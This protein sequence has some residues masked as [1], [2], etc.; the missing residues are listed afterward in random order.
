MQSTA[1]K[2][3]SRI[4]LVTFILFLSSTILKAQ[5]RG[6]AGIPPAKVVV[7]GVTSGMVA[8]QSIFVGTVYYQEVADVA[9]EVNGLV[10]EVSFEEGERIEKGDV[11]VKLN[12]DLL[13]KT[14]Q[15]TRASYEKV[16][17]DL[18]KARIDFKR[19]ESLY[20]EGLASEQEYDE[21]GFRVKGQEK[22]AES[23]KAELERLEAE[24][25]R[26]VIKAPF[27]GVVLERQANIGEWLSPGS[28]VATIARSEVVDIVVN[29]PEEVLR[30]IRQGQTVRVDSG[31]EDIK[32]KVFTI[33]PKGDVATRTF[34]VKIR[35][36][37]NQS[38]LEGMEARVTLP[39]GKN[40][41]S[42]IVPRDAVI[43]APGNTVVFAVVDSKARIIPVVV[44][45]YDGMMAWVDSKALHEGMKVVIKGNERLRDS[46]PVDVLVKQ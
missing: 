6:T 24:S 1:D 17:T 28:P 9:S 25:L 38:L 39:V 5:E 42:L 37:N 34:P 32:G 43:T 3:L 8:P 18:E 35:V 15:A 19:V 11:L 22:M 14:I 41:K 40:R 4:L 16:I 45:G 7:S 27:D 23:L 44:T 13:Q 31:G 26:K 33:M 21:N 10:E 46:Q 36:Q 2:W 20:K 29:V 30:F 12:A